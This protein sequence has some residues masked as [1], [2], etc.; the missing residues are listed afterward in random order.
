MFL[1]LLALA[2]FITPK[3]TIV[4][5]FFYLIFCSIFLLIEYKK[6]QLIKKKAAAISYDEKFQKFLTKE[7]KEELDLMFT[8]GKH[9]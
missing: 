7:E 4:I 3:L 8:T 9:K 6:Y 2:Y 5:G 1:Y